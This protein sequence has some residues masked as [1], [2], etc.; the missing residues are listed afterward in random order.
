[1]QESSSTEGPNQLIMWTEVLLEKLKVSQV[2]EKFPTFHRAQRFY[3]IKNYIE[4]IPQS[5][6]NVYCFQNSLQHVLAELAI[7]RWYIIC[8][9]YW[10]IWYILYI[11]SKFP[12]CHKNVVMNSE[13]DTNLLWLMDNLCTVLRL[14]QRYI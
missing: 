4:I 14:S 7:F 3:W 2:V 5:Q 10:D 12:G 8:T 11:M 9:K 1:V 6:L 13:N